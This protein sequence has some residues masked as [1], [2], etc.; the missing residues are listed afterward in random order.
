MSESFYEHRDHA[1]FL[2][3][4]YQRVPIYDIDELIDFCIE[5]SEWCQKA[6]QAGYDREHDLRLRLQRAHAE[7]SRLMRHT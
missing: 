3:E 7:T 6:L 1:H 5:R 4:L 2:E